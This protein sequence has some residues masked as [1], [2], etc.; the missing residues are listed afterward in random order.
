[1][2]D[3]ISKNSDKPQEKDHQS[4]STVPGSQIK[5]ADD[6]ATHIRA[7]QR[8]GLATFRLTS[9][10][11]QSFQIDRSSEGATPVTDVRHKSS[12]SDSST[13]KVGAD[14]PSSA[15]LAQKSEREA[16][17]DGTHTVAQTAARN[18]IDQR[19][20]KATG[21]M[22]TNAGKFFG[23]DK[24]ARLNIKPDD[25]GSAVSVSLL[26]P[27]VCQL[28]GADS[29]KQLGRR[30]IAFGL[31]PAMGAASEASDRVTN[32]LAD[33]V[34][35]GAANFGIGT[36]AGAIMERLNPFL[37]VAGATVGIGLSV[38]DQVYSPDHQQRN[39]ELQWISQRL[40]KASTADLIAMSNRSK[41]LLGNDVYQGAFGILAGGVGLPEGHALS[42]ATKEE[43][44]HSL[45]S[46][47]VKKVARNVSAT[48]ADL[49]RSMREILQPA[50]KFATAEGPALHN[51]EQSSTENFISRMQGKFFPLSEVMDR[52]KNVTNKISESSSQP[53]E[54][55]MRTL[56]QARKDLTEIAK[57]YNLE[58]KETA[59]TNVLENALSHLV[60]LKNAEHALMAQMKQIA[61]E[62]ND[63]LK[64]A[65]VD[66][67][68]KI[69]PG[70]RSVADGQ[71]LKDY[72]EKQTF[73]A[74][75]IRQF[76]KSNLKWD[77][78]ARGAAFP[79][80]NSS[81]VGELAQN[82]VGK[83][84][85]RMLTFGRNDPT[86]EKIFQARGLSA[87][88]LDDWV[89]L[90]TATGSSADHGGMDYALVNKKTGQVIPLDISA[91]VESKTLRAGQSIDS[92]GLNPKIELGKGK[93]MPYERERFLLAVDWP[94]AKKDN[95]KEPLAEILADMMSK[96]SH[97]TVFDSLPS[98]QVRPWMRQIFE[99]DQFRDAL[100]SKNMTNW[101]HSLR[102]SM[103]D[104][105]KHGDNQ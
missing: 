43:L 49:L 12:Q 34:C 93:R 51:I 73:I 61:S 53:T 36:A 33:T 18:E 62:V 83:E 3:K 24:I 69:E 90:P 94:N 92:Y 71:V 87:K 88:S 59:S 16:T 76:L 32:H 35:D 85:L 72:A 10:G 77:G 38:R 45:A 6:N 30:I 50:P 4:D 70:L 1:M 11:Q 98:G 65:A 89:G 21:E 9:D 15:S 67:I 95:L 20:Q 26:G 22:L 42:S 103:M 80:A 101:A 25:I 2:T 99:L 91:N 100:M 78:E 48:G 57:K 39:H 40:D 41:A 79:D 105:F 66:A 58:T 60:P 17:T 63:P 23:A 14:T 8:K 97:L 68:K 82:L 28:L 81:N 56:D 64:I 46:I 44:A 55:R 84:L 104:I 5:T 37:A 86:V 47:N 102:S 75:E 31:A 29:T 19:C 54:E 13:S 27:D 7:Q 74:F 96:D 52:A